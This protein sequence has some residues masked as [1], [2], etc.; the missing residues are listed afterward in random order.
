M[1]AASDQ[2]DM[3]LWDRLSPARE[4]IRRAATPTTANLKLQRRVRR[5]TST[6][7]LQARASQSEEIEYDVDRHT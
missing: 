1:I 7:S 3:S 5:P 4:S 6:E 2:L